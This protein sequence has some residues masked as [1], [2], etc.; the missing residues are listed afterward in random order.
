MKALKQSKY[1]TGVRNRSKLLFSQM[2]RST[3]VKDT[4]SCEM[5]LVIAMFLESLSSS[6][7]SL[8]NPENSLPTFFSNT[9]SRQG[10]TMRLFIALSKFQR[11]TT[12]GMI[13]S[14][15]S[16]R[17]LKSLTTAATRMSVAATNIAL[18]FPKLMDIVI[19]GA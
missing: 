11:D 2:H 14:C 13:L 1:L 15:L 8:E 12:T 4:R 16:H 7:I 6:P 10:M 9:P 5:C 19:L 18:I 3:Y 17:D